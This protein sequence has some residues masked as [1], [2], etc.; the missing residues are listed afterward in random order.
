M[1]MTE[2]THDTSEIK[3]KLESGSDHARKAWE[4]TSEA[5]KN[6]GSTLK[7]EAN[8]AFTRGK[9]HMEKAVKSFGE[10]ASETCCTLRGQAQ[11]KVQEYRTKAE[12]ALE[13]AASRA[14]NM[15][16]KTEDYIRTNPLKAVGLALGAGF[17]LAAILRRR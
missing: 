12:S 17:L 3:A 10:A 11:E 1:D 6:L 7:K 14:K 9:E 5:A 8:E 16:N 2:D 4:A 15:Q 13:E